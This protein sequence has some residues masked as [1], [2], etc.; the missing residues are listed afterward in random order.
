MNKKIL[1]IIIIFILLLLI[2]GGLMLWYYIPK[3]NISK[4]ETITKETLDAEIKKTFGKDYEL[5]D[6]TFYN[7]RTWALGH[8]S[9]LTFQADEA[10]VIYYK[11]EGDNW[12]L[13]LGPT[14]SFEDEDFSK[15]N[16][17]PQELKQKIGL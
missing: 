11:K 8:L 9:P 12:I 7:N 13:F 2:I 5:K 10:V 3:N 4:I 16:Q 15:L 14:T 17:L 1:I 6:L